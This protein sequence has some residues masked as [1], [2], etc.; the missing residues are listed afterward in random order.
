[1]LGTPALFCIWKPDFGGHPDFKQTRFIPQ[2]PLLNTHT[3]E[4]SGRSVGGKVGKKVI[5]FI[6]KI[7]HKSSLAVS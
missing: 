6:K 4:D 5:Y 1:M 3:Q 7:L 2:A